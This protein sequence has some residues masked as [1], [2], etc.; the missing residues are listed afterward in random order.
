MTTV[1]TPNSTTWLPYQGSPGARGYIMSTMEE[2]PNA[3]AAMLTGHTQRR[4]WKAPDGCQPL[5]LATSAAI[6][7]ILKPI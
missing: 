1:P 3:S 5:K 7:I 6:T 4:S 2:T